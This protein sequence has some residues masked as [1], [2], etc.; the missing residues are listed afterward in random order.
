MRIL[1]IGGTGNISSEV[2]SQLYSMGH[3]ITILSSGSRPVPA[4]C[5][6]IKANKFN[7]GELQNCLKDISVDAAIDFMAFTPAHCRAGYRALRGKT[8]QFIFISSATV[9]Q[10]PHAK[11]PVTEDTPRG[12]PFWP[13]AQD[14]IACEEYLESIHGD[15]FPVTIVRPSHTFGQTWIPS[16]INGCG[17]TVSSR[18]KNGKPFII[19]DKGESLWT[20]TASSDFAKGFVGLVGNK[21][22]IGEAF[23]ITSDETLSWNA[24][25]EE[26]GKALGASIK[27]VHIPSEFIAKVYP[28][29]RGML[30]GDKREPGVFDNSKIKKFAPGFKC[31]KSFSAAIKESVDWFMED[32]RRRQIDMAE[33]RLIEAIIGAWENSKYIPASAYSE[34][35]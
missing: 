21:N 12:N 25:Y 10:K 30:M 2:T 20:L 18:I 19:H 17:F 32:P 29:A 13:Y 8:E 5:R 27:P 6:H 4:G 9:Y 16:P 24:I 35:F 3:E 28:D 11:I 14:K 7:D 1:I 15:D 26:L 23:H 22:A 34:Q 31:E 33:D